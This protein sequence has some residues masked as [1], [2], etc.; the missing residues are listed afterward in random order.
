MEIDRLKP[1]LEKVALDVFSNWHFKCS[2][3][4]HGIVLEPHT[5]SPVQLKGP[6]SNRS[7][8]IAKIEN[9]INEIVD[10]IYKD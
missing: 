5:F 9:I 4:W 10:R 2:E 7:R 1:E 8:N 6:I 3:H